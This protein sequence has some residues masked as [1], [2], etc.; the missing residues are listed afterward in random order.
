MSEA[1]AAVERAIQELRARMAEFRQITQQ[2]MHF[3]QISDMVTARFDGDGY[4]AD[5]FIDPAAATSYTHTEL[6]DLLTEVL[7]DQ[8]ERTRATVN[9]IFKD[10]FKP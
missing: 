8:F 2:A 6:E 9:E 4:L 1:V 10:F 3:D 7:R 5:L